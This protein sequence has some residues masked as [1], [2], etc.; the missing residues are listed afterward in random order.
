MLKS[1]AWAATPLKIDDLL[2]YGQEEGPILNEIKVES[3]ISAGEAEGAEE[4][5]L[6]SEYGSRDVFHGGAI[7][8]TVPIKFSEL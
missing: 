5:A 4:S 2:V 6:I 7:L 1:G 8:L 3:A